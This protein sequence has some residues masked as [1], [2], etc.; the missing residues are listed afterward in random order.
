VGDESSTGE[1]STLNPKSPQALANIGEGSRD[2]SSM[3]EQ[4]ALAGFET[5]PSQASIGA[6]VQSQVR[7]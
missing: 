3:G 7:A 6:D 2:E 1:P 5:A 4:D